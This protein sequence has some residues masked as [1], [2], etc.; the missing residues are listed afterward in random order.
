MSRI[1]K[2]ILSAFIETTD[3]KKEQ[4]PDRD[5]GN[6][7]GGSGTGGTGGSRTNRSSTSGNS[8]SESGMTGSGVA[9]SSTTGYANTRTIPDEGN[10][11]AGNPRF[12]E[13]FDK[14]F[15][16]ANIPGPDYYEFSKMIE[17]MQAIPDEQARFYA[18]YAGLQVQGLDKEKLLSTAGE[19]LRILSADA[20]H[21]QATVDSAL[22]EK[23]QRRAAE[24]EEKGERIRQLSREILELQGQITALQTEI[25]ENKEKIEASSGGYAVECERRKARIED[26]IEKIKHYI[27]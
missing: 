21:F 24:A 19:Y 16:E 26:D 8:T 15:S 1:G 3:D 2:K 18:A 4:N 22:Q 9:G 10:R 25:R 6:N 20:G 14:L 17:A 5:G 13:Y 27:H 7:A 12:I 11:P 23:V